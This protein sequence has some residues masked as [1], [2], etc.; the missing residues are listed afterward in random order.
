MKK[1][2]LVVLLVHVL[3]LTSCD[4]QISYDPVEQGVW[5]SVVGVKSLLYLWDAIDHYMPAPGEYY[6]YS[7]Q[8]DGKDYCRLKYTVIPNLETICFTNFDCHG[9]GYSDVTLNGTI[10]SIVAS[11]SITY[12]LTFTGDGVPDKNNTIEYVL[13]I[14]GDGSQILTI[15]GIMI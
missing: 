4:G 2:F 7:E 12:M 11:G 15:N 13:F 14:N 1:I 8:E 5:A 6:E 3:I 10:V 9:I